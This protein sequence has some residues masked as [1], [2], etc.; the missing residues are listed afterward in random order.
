MRKNL[1]HIQLINGQ[2]SN[3]KNQKSENN[4]LT[5]EGILLKETYS[6]KDIESLEHLDFGAG[7]APTIIR[8]LKQVLVLRLP[9]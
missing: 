5:A 3:V 1:Q 2:K 4:F 9:R 8:R 6:E 7:L